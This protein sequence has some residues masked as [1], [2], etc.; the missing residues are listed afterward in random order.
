MIAIV[1]FFVLATTTSYGAIV[2]SIV[3]D[4]P[5]VSKVVEGHLVIVEKRHRSRRSV[6]DVGLINWR[7]LIWHTP[8]ARAKAGWRTSRAPDHVFAGGRTS[9][10]FRLID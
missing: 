3:G 7:K 6:L 1:P 5:V 8:T 4:G 10:H 2:E 9:N